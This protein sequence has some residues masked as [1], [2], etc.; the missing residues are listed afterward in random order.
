[1]SGFLSDLQQAATDAGNWYARM[2]SATNTRGCIWDGQSE[3]GRKHREALGREAFP[4]EGAADTRVRT[5]DEIC[6]EQA[7]LMFQAFSR[8]R[9]QATGINSDDCSWGRR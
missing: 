7:M 5:V 1:M 2:D 6:N 3:D 4:W 9:I 8:S